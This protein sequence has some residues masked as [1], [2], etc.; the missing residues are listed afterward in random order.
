MSDLG[1]LAFV[2]DVHLD[3]NDADLPEV[4][5]FL[6]ALGARAGRIVLMGDLFNLWIGE[7]EV[8]QPH[9]TAVL[10]RL[11]AARSRGIEVHYVEGN[12]D[13][14]VAKG[15][16]GAVFDRVGDRGLEE[17][18]AG[19]KIFAVHGDLVNV[20][21]RQYRTWRRVSRSAPVWSLFGLLPAR[22][23]LLLAESLE[24]RMRSTNVRMKRSF[25]AGLVRG[26]A[27]PYLRSGFDAVV[28]GHFHEEH[29]IDETEVPGSIFVLPDWKSSRRY[30]RVGPDGSIEFR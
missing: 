29:R 12:R 23:R 26:Y 17:R 8:E 16:G 11:A 4:L 3:R 9:Q 18:W 10:E 13:Y 28:L 22:T 1:E 25:P 24:V 7:R 27:R 30:L 14:A 2:G 6:D 19:R 15:Y 20:A 5:G 21:D